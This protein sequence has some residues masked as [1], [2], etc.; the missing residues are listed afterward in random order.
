[1]DQSEVY[2]DVFE[3]FE[4]NDYTYANKYLKVGWRLLMIGSTATAQNKRTSYI[5]GWI[6]SHTPEYPKPRKGKP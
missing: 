3:L 1:M 6:K 5:L 4:T 2:R